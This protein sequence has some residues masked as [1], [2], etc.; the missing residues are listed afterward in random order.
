MKRSNWGVIRRRGIGAVCL[1][2]AGLGIAR[3]GRLDE[4]P[5]FD[6]AGYATLG[7]ALASG[8]GYRDVGHPDAP[9]H[10]HFPPGYPAALAAVWTIRR[11]VSLP[12]AHGFSMACTLVGV[13]AACRWWRTTEPRTAAALLGLALAANWTWARVGASIQSEPLFLAVGGTVVLLATRAGRLGRI[14]DGAAVGIGLAACVLTRHV[15]AC[16]ALAVVLDL[17]L[18]GRGRA[19]ATAAGV[20]AVLIAPWIA[21]Q[22][23][24]G[25]GTQAGLFRPRELPGLVASQSLFYARRIPD[26]I[27]GPFVEAATVFG[28]SP[29]V[30]AL[31]TA[32]AVAASAVVGFGWA[33]MLRDPR[34]RLGALI[35]LVTL[36]LL[37]AWP[38]TEAGR[39]LIPLV[40][41][42][43]MGAVEGLA[44]AARLLGT[45][46]PRTHAA[47]CV[48]LLTLP[49]AAYALMSDRAGVQRRTQA[50]FDA[51][52]AWIKGRGDHP[53]VVMARH[54][55]DVAWLTG[56]PAVATPDGGPDAIDRAIRRYGV[57]YLLVDD[58]RYA[59]AATNPL[60]AFI[61]RSAGRVRAVPAG[62][63]KVAIYEIVPG[64][65]P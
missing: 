19:A 51:A 9:A 49:Y 36:T 38:F 65:S 42:L 31:A 25:S 55:S 15:G 8:R 43:L 26:A 61:A 13:G 34:R 24:T 11:G 60:R 58:D 10:A 29:A 23:A 30:S 39:F 27:A 14:R 33:R 57:A 22:G 45:R 18:R 47:A 1:V 40:P 3:S 5:R 44:P 35:P 4:P 64:A 37:V 62:G 20:A 12:W 2:V 6:G 54:P 56:R 28:R 48:L 7:A 59:N 21:W 53:G 50:D 63:G 52:C 16:L 46:R 17:G 32:G 41:G